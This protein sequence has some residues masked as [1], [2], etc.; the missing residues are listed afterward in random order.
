MTDFIVPLDDKV[1]DFGYH[2]RANARTILSSRFGDGKSYFLNTIRN[3]QVLAKEF[4]FLTLYPCKLSS[5]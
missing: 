4:E 3:D 2:L 5:G 1:K